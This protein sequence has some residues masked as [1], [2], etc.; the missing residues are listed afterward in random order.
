MFLTINAIKAHDHNKKKSFAFMNSKSAPRVEEIKYDD[1][2]EYDDDD[3]VIAYFDLLSDDD[4]D[5]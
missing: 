5:E 1:E 3:E 2:Y 4:D